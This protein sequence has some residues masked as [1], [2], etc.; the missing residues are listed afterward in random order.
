MEVTPK[1][2][3]K[4]AHVAGHVQLRLLFYSYLLLNI[5]FNKNKLRLCLLQGSKGR[6][7]LLEELV[8]FLKM[9]KQQM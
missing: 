7:T 3:V 9:L 1:K 2:R 8:S 6:F 5:A 4:R